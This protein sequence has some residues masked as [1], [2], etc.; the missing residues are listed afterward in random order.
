MGENLETIPP[1]AILKTLSNWIKSEPSRPKIC[2][3]IELARHNYDNDD[4]KNEPLIEL[5]RDKEGYEWACIKDQ[6]E[7]KKFTN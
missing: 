1:P 5:F 2:Q 6:N 4:Y 3:F 7:N